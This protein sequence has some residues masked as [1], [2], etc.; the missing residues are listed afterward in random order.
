MT[1]K[2]QK[3]FDVSDEYLCPK[4]VHITK[5]VQLDGGFKCTNKTY[6]KQKFKGNMS[7]SKKGIQDI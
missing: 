1:V 6:G 7:Y 3:H 2:Q 5:C 4:T